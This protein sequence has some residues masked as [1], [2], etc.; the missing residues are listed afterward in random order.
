MALALCSVKK[1]ALAF[2]G[3]RRGHGRLLPGSRIPLIRGR[4]FDE[5]RT[6]ILRTLP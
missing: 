5:A 6:R 3:F 1:T 4:I 2:A